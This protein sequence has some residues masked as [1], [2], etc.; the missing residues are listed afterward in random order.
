MND[1]ITINQII[2]TP[3]TDAEYHVAIQAVLNEIERA[4]VR[5]T[6]NQDEIDRLRA[7]TRIMLDKL[8]SLVS[9]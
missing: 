2:P 6:Q 1:A 3:Q 5:M 9:R 4:N 7:E 8:P